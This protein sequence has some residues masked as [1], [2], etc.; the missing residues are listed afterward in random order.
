L[1]QR[2][3]GEAYVPRR[4]EALGRLLLEAPAHDAIERRGDRAGA[5]LD[6][7]RVLAQD[8]GERV[9][10]RRAAERTLARHH[11]VEDGAEGE[12]VAPRVCGP[13]SRLLGRHVGYRAQ[14]HPRRGHLPGSGL[15][16]ALAVEAQRVHACEAEVE[17]LG[18]PV[19]RQ[20]DVL[21]LE[22]SVDDPL[23]VGGREP[24][25]DLDRDLHRLARR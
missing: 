13:A 2:L 4:L 7:R 20:E 22:V 15:G 8:G 9:G 14:E 10:R 3:E 23:L 6:R 18:S 1:R 12:D 11:L 25:R 16:L 17:D 24:S 5:R 21:G 19:S